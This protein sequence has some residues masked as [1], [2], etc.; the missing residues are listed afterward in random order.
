MN[1]NGCMQRGGVRQFGIECDAAAHTDDRCKR[2]H[3]HR[4][5]EQKFFSRNIGAIHSNRHGK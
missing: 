5:Q 1:A 4:M 3:A 2:E